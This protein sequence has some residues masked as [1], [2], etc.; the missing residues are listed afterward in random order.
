MN[1]EDQSPGNLDERMHAS[2]FSAHA[3]RSKDKI[4]S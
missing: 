2:R 4:L 3:T 1:G